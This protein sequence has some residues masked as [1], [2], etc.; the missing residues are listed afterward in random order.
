[1]P[2]IRLYVGIW[3]GLVVAT[4]MEVVT[5]SLPGAA[6]LLAL[7]IL[8]IASAKAIFIALYYQHLRFESWRLA[9]LP[10]SAIIG[11]ALLAISA[12]FSMNMGG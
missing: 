7:T 5:R 8:L 9:V 11:I 12:A 2:G 10:I 4:V 3:A 1:M 6:S